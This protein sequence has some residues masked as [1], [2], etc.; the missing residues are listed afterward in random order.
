MN[1]THTPGTWMLPSG[2]IDILCFSGSSPYQLVDATG[3]G[4]PPNPADMRLIA[5]A[6]DLLAACREFRAAEN[7]VGDARKFALV[8]ARTL[9][10]AAIARAEGR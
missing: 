9:C 2:S 7:L 10:S 6:P 3:N 8:N 5:A 4:Y 1:A